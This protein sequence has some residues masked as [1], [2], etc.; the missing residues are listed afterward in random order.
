MVPVHDSPAAPADVNALVSRTLRTGGGDDIRVGGVERKSPLALRPGLRAY[1]AQEVDPARASAPLAAYC[2]MTGFMDAVTFSAVS[3]W[4]GFQTGNTIELALALARFLTAH[5]PAP[6]SPAP[7]TPLAPPHTASWSDGPTP[8]P[9]LAP[10]TL[11]SLGAFLLGAILARLGDAALFAPPRPRPNPAADADTETGTGTVPAPPAP[12]R[13]AA[14]NR[15]WLVSGTLLQAALTLLAA[16][17]VWLG[18]RAGRAATLPFAALG[19]E[20][21]V[22]ATWYGYVAIALASAS[23]GLQGGMGKKLGTG[24]ATTVVLTS[25][26]LDL[27]A[28][29][30]SKPAPKPKPAPRAP[31]ALYRTDTYDDTYDDDAYDLPG[32]ASRSLKTACLQ[33][34]LAAAQK[35][36]LFPLRATRALLAP[37]LTPRPLAILALFLGGLVGRLAL[38][39]AGVVGALV[40]AAVVRAAVAVA[41][42][43]VPR[44]G[45][46][47]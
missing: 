2:F 12:P 5:S 11:T 28:S 8:A 14:R 18:V 1:M 31:L 25:V 36:L 9:L 40:G 41:W 32:G 35:A 42:A 17:L 10:H 45:A 24:F 39:R 6:R 21:P 4:C 7:I 20:A 43:R 33:P 44:V 34:L 19:P 15:A 46:G 47:K 30:L 23:M 27:L 13:N 38:V 22:W 29:P 37:L 26:W 16:A 3:V